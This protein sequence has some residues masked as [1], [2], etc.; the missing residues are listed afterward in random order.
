MAP[1]LGTSPAE[2]FNYLAEKDRIKSLRKADRANIILDRNENPLYVPTSISSFVKAYDAE[3]RNVQAKNPDLLS[4][5]EISE[6]VS[7]LAG[8]IEKFSYNKWAEQPVAWTWQ[9]VIQKAVEFEENKKSQD[10]TQPSTAELVGT[11]FPTED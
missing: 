9:G 1:I 8:R 6:R 7:T 10:I 5:Q 4:D 2:T 11:L 3:L